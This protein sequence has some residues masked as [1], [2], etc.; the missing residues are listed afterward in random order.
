MTRGFL[1]GLFWGG[2]VSLIALF[3]SNQAL[4]RQTLSFPKPEATAVDVPG[5]SEFNQARPET[6]PVVPTVD[7]RPENSVSAGVPVPEEEDTTPPTLD[8]TA[9]E[10]PVP[11]TTQ[12]APD[13]LGEAPDEV[14][15]TTEPEISSEDAIDTPLAEPL[16]APE[17]P[18]QAPET[19]VVAVETPNVSVT[20]DAAP[21]IDVSEVTA[22]QPEPAPEE[23]P[24]PLIIIHDTP[25]TG[26]ETDVAALPDTDAPEISS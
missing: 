11:E 21:E 8:V 25:A 12:E 1:S 14:A 3:V 17:T 13:S 2:I 9:L 23:E 4:D 24:A 10:V 26:E 7:T 20:E 19:E 15:D 18:G 6:D 16:V 5:G 22:P